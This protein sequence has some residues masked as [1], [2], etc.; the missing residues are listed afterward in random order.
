MEKF[1]RHNLLH[2]AS[3]YR[4]LTG[5]SSSWLGLEIMRNGKFFRDLAGDPPRES[6]PS[7]YDTVMDWFAANWPADTA[8]PV[9]LVD[10]LALRQ[11]EARNSYSCSGPLPR[12]VVPGPDNLAADAAHA[13]KLAGAA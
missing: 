11:W 12:I 3:D 13:T 2:C 7:K 10:H 6:M 4:A 1:T 9:C 5:V 8:M